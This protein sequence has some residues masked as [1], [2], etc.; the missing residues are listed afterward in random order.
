MF[1]NAG[2]ATGLQETLLLSYQGARR[3]CDHRDTAQVRLL[4]HPLGQRK[5]ILIVKLHIE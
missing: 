2:V 5:S 3:H 1:R 4:P